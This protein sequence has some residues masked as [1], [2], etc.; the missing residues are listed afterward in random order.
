MSFDTLLDVFANCLL[1]LPTDFRIAWGSTVGRCLG[2]GTP[3]I[4]LRRVRLLITRPPATPA[5]AA[6]TAT[7]GPF[8]LLATF[9]TVSVMPLLLLRPFVD[10]AVAERFARPLFDFAV[11]RVVRLVALA[12]AV[13]RVPRLRPFEPLGV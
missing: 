5:A 1:A 3:R 8:A 2:T 9:L 10:A 4:V 11:L 7:A 6:P 13:L 12:F